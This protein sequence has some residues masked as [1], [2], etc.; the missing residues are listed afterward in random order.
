MISP[1]LAIRLN[2]ERRDG[3]GII[4]GSPEGVPGGRYTMDVRKSFK[5]GKTSTFL[6]Y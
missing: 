3:L 2:E 5:Q 6:W 1:G 4:A